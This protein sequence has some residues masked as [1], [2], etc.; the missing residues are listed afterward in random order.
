MLT[1]EFHLFSPCRGPKHGGHLMDRDFRP[2]SQGELGLTI[3][4][5]TQIALDDEPMVCRELGHDP[6]QQPDM[7]GAIAAR[8]EDGGGP[9]GGQLERVV[10][11]GFA[12]STISGLRSSPLRPHLPLGP[13]IGLDRDGPRFI[14][15]DLDDG[16]HLSMRPS[17]LYRGDY[18]RP[19]SAQKTIRFGNARISE[20]R[21]KFWDPHVMTV[22][23]VEFACHSM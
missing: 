13:R 9:Y 18:A 3:D 20:S 15:T 21:P 22:S 10:N 16:S 19:I 1:T 17:P 14:H 11:P 5:G 7:G 4:V 12:S 8:A 6:L 2:S 23:E